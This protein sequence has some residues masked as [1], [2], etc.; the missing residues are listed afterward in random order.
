MSIRVSFVHLT[1]SDNEQ[2]KRE[3]L[4]QCHDVLSPDNLALALELFNKW[5]DLVASVVSDLEFGVIPC[6]K[7]AIA[8]HAQ[9]HDNT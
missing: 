6:A 5:I 7:E 1:A 3:K 9:Y 8:S 2:D 4:K